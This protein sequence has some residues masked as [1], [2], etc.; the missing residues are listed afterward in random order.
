MFPSVHTLLPHEF[1]Y[2]NADSNYMSL[3]C[4]RFAAFTDCVHCLR[5]RLTPIIQNSVLL[6]RAPH[7]LFIKVKAAPNE[8]N[9]ISRRNS[10]A[11]DLLPGFTAS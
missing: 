4:V 2:M 10:W 1:P 8:F 3:H 11:P 9:D 7:N 5:L 6:S